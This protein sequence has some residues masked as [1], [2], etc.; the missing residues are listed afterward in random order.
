MLKNQVDISSLKRVIVTAEQ[1]ILR[2]FTVARPGMHAKDI[3]LV[4]RDW[5]HDQEASSLQTVTVKYG[6]MISLELELQSEL[7]DGD[8]LSINL[9]GRLNQVAFDLTRV[10]VVGSPAAQQKDYLDHLREATQWMIE[11][12]VTGRKMTFY[13]AESRK[14]LITPIAYEIDA[15]NRH[16]Q[17]ITAREEFSLPIGMVL[18]IAPTI[19]SREFGTM[20]HSEMVV[21]TENGA[22]LL[23]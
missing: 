21:L 19:T 6:K 18:C 7:C 2:G 8:F 12:I 13:P 23:S 3:E 4:V 9:A 11:T 14:R 20:T 22:E 1:G 16:V 17:R 5:L 15:D 10:A